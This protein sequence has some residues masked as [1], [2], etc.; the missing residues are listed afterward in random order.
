LIDFIRKA[1]KEYNL[2]IGLVHFSS[3]FHCDVFDIQNVND[4]PDKLFGSDNVYLFQSRPV[5]GADSDYKFTGDN[6]GALY[7]LVGTDNEIMLRESSIS[8]ISDDE[9]VAFWKKVVKPFKQSML[10]GAWVINP[11]NGAKGFYKNLYYTYQAKA[12]YDS[13]VKI[14]PYGGSNIVLL[15]KE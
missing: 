3:Q 4:F 15:E 14:T 11:F 9:T 10:K 12:A 6:P 13:G 8:T 1:A 5:L 2:I 7:I